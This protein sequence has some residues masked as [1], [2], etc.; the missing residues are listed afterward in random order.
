MLVVDLHGCIVLANGPA[1]ELFEA[2][3]L[4]LVGTSVDRWLPLLAVALKCLRPFGAVHS[5]GVERIGVVAPQIGVRLSGD[6]F[7]ADLIVHS[8]TNG[9]DSVLLVG[10]RS[11]A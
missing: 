6:P 5:P 10:I 9:S 11:M 7:A 4:D 1:E 8:W 2:S 3:C